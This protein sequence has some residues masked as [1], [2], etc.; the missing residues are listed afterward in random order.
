MGLIQVRFL[1]S[2][3][4]WGRVRE[5]LFLYANDVIDGFILVASR[6]NLSEKSKVGRDMTL[7]LGLSY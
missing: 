1:L 6:G 3:E 4:E 5:L 2:Q 7:T